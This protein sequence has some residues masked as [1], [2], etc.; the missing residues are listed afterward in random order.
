V[1]CGL[2]L[3]AC[4]TL[5]A[6]AHEQT[7]VRSTP[8]CFPAK[9]TRRSDAAESILLSPLPTH[10]HA[11]R[12][13]ANS[14]LEMAAATN[15]AP[16]GSLLES[17]REVSTAR[18]IAVREAWEVCSLALRLYS[19]LAHWPSLSLRPCECERI[20]LMAAHGQILGDAAARGAYDE[21][22]LG[23]ARSPPRY[24]RGRLSVSVPYARARW[25]ARSTSR[26]RRSWCSRGGT[27][28]TKEGIWRVG[29]AP[30]CAHHCVPECPA[31]AQIPRWT[32]PAELGIAGWLTAAGR[33]GAREREEGGRERV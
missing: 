7:P 14:S 16:Q 12:P 26:T 8:C 31:R 15:N 10:A 11:T 30:P 1:S 6:H 25:Y 22:R 18:F 9:W 19:C 17:G 21:N 33:Q 5:Y 29:N 13:L 24:V 27:S 2:I 20:L 3:C 4:L 28:R 23:R 32:V